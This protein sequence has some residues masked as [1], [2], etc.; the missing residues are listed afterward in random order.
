MFGIFGQVDGSL[1]GRI[2]TAGHKYMLA[3]HGLGFGDA[4]TI[5]DACPYQRLEVWDAKPL[6]VG[7]HSQHDCAAGNLRA[8]G[9]LQDVSH[10]L[11]CAGR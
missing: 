8:I 1:A 2:A 7:A 5:E 9:T 10:C 6:V 3:G 11:Q 4:A